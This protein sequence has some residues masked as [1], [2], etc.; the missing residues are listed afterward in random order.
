MKRLKY[1]GEHLGTCS[2]KSLSKSVSY[3]ERSCMIERKLPLLSFESSSLDLEK[4]KLHF[5]N[6]NL[7]FTSLSKTFFQKFVFSSKDLCNAFSVVPLFLHCSYVT[8]ALH[9]VWNFHG[10]AFAVINASRRLNLLYLKGFEV[11]KKSL[12]RDFY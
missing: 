7:T 5:A 10:F 2:C 6:I 4:G 8:H 9:D 1:F 12:E 3:L 11:R